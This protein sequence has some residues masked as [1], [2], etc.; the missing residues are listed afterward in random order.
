MGA[1]LFPT[2]NSLP[3]LLWSVSIVVIGLGVVYLGHELG[4]VLAAKAFRL[5]LARYYFGFDTVANPLN[6]AARPVW[7]RMI[8]IL[9]GPLMSL[10]MAVAFAS[11]AYRFGVSYTPCIIGGTSPGEPAWELGLRPG[12]KILQIGRFGKPNEHLRFTKD[13]MPA[14]ILNGS[15]RSPFK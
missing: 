15:D 13:L 6:F 9:A 10:L 1:W 7:Q 11:V 4:H 5:K 2:G 14:I 8:I 3:G 12:D